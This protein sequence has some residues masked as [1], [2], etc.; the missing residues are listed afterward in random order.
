MGLENNTWSH[1]LFRYREE[2][3]KVHNKFP[4]SLIPYTDKEW[5]IIP[6]KLANRTTVQN[7]MR[8]L[9]S[10]QKLLPEGADI[11]EYTLH[12]PRN[13]FTNATSLLGFPEQ[14]QTILGR[15]SQHSRMPFRYTRAIAT[16]ELEMRRN[17]IDRISK[18]WAPDHNQL[19]PSCQSDRKITGPDVHQLD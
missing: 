1:E 13:F 2:F 9:I 7:R 4:P 10:E 15:W 14:D 19:P 11:N 3:H 8:D 16:K 12:S 18:G 17:V 6:E 5:T